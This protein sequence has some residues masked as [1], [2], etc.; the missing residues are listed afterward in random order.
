MKD[1]LGFK[2]Y[3]AEVKTV[4][5]DINILFP[6]W[7]EDERVCIMSPHDDDAIIGA[8]YGMLAARQAGAEVYVYIFCRGDAGY[9]T[10]AEKETI[11]DI[12]RQEA[13]ACYARMGIPRDHIFRMNFGDFSAIGNLG[14]TT[15][16][17]KQGDMPRMLRFLRDNRI[18]RVMVPNHY[19]EHID[20]LAAHIMACYNIPQAGDPVLVDHATPHSVK[21]VLE[22]SV[23]ADFDP[24][25][26]MV[27]KRDTNIRAN[28]II[29]ASKEVEGIIAECI[30][31]YRSQGEIIRDLIASR[32]ERRMKDGRS[33]ETYIA[34]DPR[35][36]MSFSP[37]I[38]LIE[39]SLENSK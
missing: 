19:H 36:K 34:L 25:D 26:A 28:R 39:Q 31:E 22:Y 32:S 29:I 7:N 30:K 8:G 21:S 16:A 6:D 18:T 10:A 3:D 15:A 1:R 4:S 2:Y 38:H 9:S 23:W 27:H 24:E 17:D 14:W 13:E 5:D 37:Y 20:H 11:E 33:I 35:P 12:R